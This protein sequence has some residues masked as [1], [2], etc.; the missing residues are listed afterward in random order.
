MPGL[1]VAVDHDISGELW[2]CTPA[3]VVISQAKDIYYTARLL[4]A[5]LG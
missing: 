5:I 1:S 3:H 4:K 2:T